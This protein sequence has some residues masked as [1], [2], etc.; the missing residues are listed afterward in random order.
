MEEAPNICARPGLGGLLRVWGCIWYD[1]SSS[2]VK[3]SD[4]LKPTTNLQLMYTKGEVTF[5]P[6]LGTRIHPPLASSAPTQL[7]S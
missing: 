5:A 3:D 7:H 6:S 2:L 1:L 4:R